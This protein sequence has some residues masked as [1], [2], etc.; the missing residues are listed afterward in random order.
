M[1]ATDKTLG[2]LHEQVAQ[3]LTEM[4]TIREV[5]EVDKDGEAHVRVE[6]PSP[7][8]LAVAV[9]FLKNNSITADIATDAATKE[10]SDKLAARGRISKQDMDD[11]LAAVRGSMLQ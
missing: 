11:A 10:L 4:V 7:S 5:T 1:A 6:H 2:K 9:A 3:T 8:A